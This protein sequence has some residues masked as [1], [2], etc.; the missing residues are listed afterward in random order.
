MTERDKM[1]LISLDYGLTL[2][3]V[4]VAWCSKGCMASSV[5]LANIYRQSEP[6]FRIIC[7]GVKELRA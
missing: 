4:E 2:L 5:E 3:D 7:A 1:R 6:K